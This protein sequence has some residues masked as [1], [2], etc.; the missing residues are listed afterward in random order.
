M[1]IIKAALMTA[2]VFAATEAVAEK[3]TLCV[4]DPLGSAGDGFNVMKDYAIEMKG[5]GV[6]FELKPYTDE[7]VAMGDFLSKKCNAVAATDLRTRQYNKF[8]GTVSAVGALPSY[9]ELKKVLKTLARPKAAK[10]MDDKKFSIMGIFPMGAGYLFVNDRSIDTVGELAGKRIATLD[11]QKDAIHMV[12]HVKSTVVPSDITNFGGKFNNGSADICYA[13]ALGYNAYE[14][15]RGLGDKGGIVRYP[16]A[17]LTMQILTFSDEFDAKSRQ[18]SREIIFG[19]YD[20]ALKVIKKNEKAIAANH[21]LDIPAKDIEKYQEM[22]RQ[23]RLELR[24]SGIYHPKLLTLMR[25]IRC[26]ESPKSSECTRA[27][28]E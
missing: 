27:D 13:P 19:L 4:F 25:K 8:S 15:Y 10:Y 12:N 14:L 16:L 24:E 20:K 2:S 7:G 1:K 9:K 26:K 5:Q 23:N 11:Y 28:K 17:Q 21:W 18:K 3:K 22:F 6:D